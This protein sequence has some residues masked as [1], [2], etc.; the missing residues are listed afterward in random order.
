MR[1]KPVHQA[2][3]E[4]RAISRSS[5]SDRFR[6]DDVAGDGVT[7]VERHAWESVARGS[8]RRVLDRV[9]LAEWRRYGEAV[10]LAD[11]YLR[12]LVDRG[13]V[14][15]LVRIALRPR[16]LA[17]ARHED[18][19]GAI[20]FQRVCDPSP[21]HQLSCHRRAAGGDVEPRVREVAWRLLA[22]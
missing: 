8:L 10:V 20:H 14:E 11:E 9:L 5:A 21:A 19:V 2:L 3:D 18:L 15:G 13:E 12:H 16:A 17:V 7:A 1:A 4:G 6:G 22:A